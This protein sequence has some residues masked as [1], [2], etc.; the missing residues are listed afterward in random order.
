VISVSLLSLL[1]PT[2]LFTVQKSGRFDRKIR[3]RCQAAVKY[4]CQSPFWGFW[5]GSVLM[6]WPLC[7]LQEVHGTVHTAKYRTTH[8]G[9]CCHFQTLS[10]RVCWEVTPKQFTK[11]SWNSSVY[12]FSL[13]V[14]FQD[15]K[16]NIFH[17]LESLEFF[18]MA[19]IVL[20]LYIYFIQHF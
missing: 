20:I 2:L 18:S 11:V 19:V 10:S 6:C 1:L 14:L 4:C 15:S 9:S 8:A 16:Y 3:A 13:L 7:V 17:K 12:L 5:C